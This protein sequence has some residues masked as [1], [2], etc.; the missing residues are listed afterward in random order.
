MLITTDIC[1]SSSSLQLVINISFDLTSLFAE[2]LVQTGIDFMT[3]APEASPPEDEDDEFMFELSDKP[4]LPSI[5]M[6]L[7]EPKK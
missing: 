6:Y 4:L 3:G 1:P 2:D 7:D 5:S